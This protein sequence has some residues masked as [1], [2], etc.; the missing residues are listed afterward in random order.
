M[1]PYLILLYSGRGFGAM[2]I[3]VLCA[4]RPWVSAPAGNL[5]VAAADAWGLHRAA[6]VGTFLAALAGRVLLSHSTGF[7]ANLV[8]TVVSEAAAAPMSVL[9]EAAVVA[10]TVDVRL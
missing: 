4:L 2:Q 6:L 1:V 7:A 10:A 9:V 8:Y 5:V 3:G